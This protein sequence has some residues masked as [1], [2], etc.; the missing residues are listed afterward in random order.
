MEATVQ[1]ILWRE[2]LAFCL[3]LFILN[4]PKPLKNIF[5]L[6]FF[7][8]REHL[9]NR[10]VANWIW[11]ERVLRSIRDPIS[12]QNKRSFNVVTSWPMKITDWLLLSRFF[13]N[14]PLKPV[15]S[16]WLVVII[17]E[18]T[19]LILLNHSFMLEMAILF[20]FTGDL[21]YKFN[22]PVGHFETYNPTNRV[23][24]RKDLLLKEE[25]IEYWVLSELTNCC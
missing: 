17:W 5:I 2:V 21:S 9:K 11:K 7:P 22:K 8:Q 12:Q 24:K 15:R 18:L 3:Q 19:P 25:K 20:I 4:E 1:S 14:S 13:F 16:N 10:V 6:L 23:Q